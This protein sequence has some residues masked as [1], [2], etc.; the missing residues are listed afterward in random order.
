MGKDSGLLNASASLSETMN[1]PLNWKQSN[2]LEHRETNS[3]IIDGINGTIQVIVQKCVEC[4]LQIGF[5][6]EPETMKE[7]VVES[8]I[9]NKTFEIKEGHLYVRLSTNNYAFY[10]ILVKNSSS[11]KPQVE[12]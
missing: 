6:T 11:L 4:H 7:E 3:Y 10:S 5:G 12:M 9:L 8:R 2:I 1:L